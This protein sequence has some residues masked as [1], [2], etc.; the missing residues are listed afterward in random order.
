[1]CRYNFD[2]K[3]KKKEI[4]IKTKGDNR[5][6]EGH[7]PAHVTNQQSSNSGGSGDKVKITLGQIWGMRAL[8]Q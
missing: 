7:L 8:K 1:M 4:E 3:K 2:L 6:Q 5:D